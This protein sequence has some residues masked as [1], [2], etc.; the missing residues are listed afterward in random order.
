[1]VRILAVYQGDPDSN[2]A[3]VLMFISN[4][5]VCVFVVHLLLKLYLHVRNYRVA[6]VS[7]LQ[8]SVIIRTLSNKILNSSVGML[9]FV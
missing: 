7:I 8:F 6:K 9:E 3:R 2:P 5:L 4:L 1:M